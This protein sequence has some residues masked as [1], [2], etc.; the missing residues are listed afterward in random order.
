MFKNFV[1]WESYRLSYRL[2]Y[3]HYIGNTPTQNIIWTLTS[4]DR[5]LDEQK[6][7]LILKKCLEVN[8]C[9][10]VKIQWSDWSTSISKSDWLLTILIILCIYCAIKIPVHFTNHKSIRIK[11]FN[12]SIKFVDE[13]ILFK[14]YVFSWKGHLERRRSCKVSSWKVWSWKVSLKLERAKRSW[15]EP[16]EVGKNRLKLESLSWSWK[17][18]D[19]VGKYNWSWKVTYEVGKFKLNL[20]RLNEVGKFQMNLERS[21]EVGKLNW[22]KGSGLKW[23][24][25]GQSGRSRG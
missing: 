9:W 15:K 10:F 17:A 23:M 18:R 25:L 16:S 14:G 12:H 3:S 6:K 5:R 2:W 21:I 13:N 7:I 22:Y 19:E 1:N 20:E 4:S 24:V 8:N 11:E